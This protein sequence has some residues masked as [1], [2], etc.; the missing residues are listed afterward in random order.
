VNKVRTLERSLKFILDC[1]QS[2]KA[3]TSQLTDDVADD[4]TLQD[5]AVKLASII[6]S[7]LLDTLRNLIKNSS[8]TGRNRYSNNLRHRCRVI[9]TKVR[10]LHECDRYNWYMCMQ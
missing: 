6:E 1:H 8:A 3:L 2:L 7:R 9:L 4:V 5:E 10:R